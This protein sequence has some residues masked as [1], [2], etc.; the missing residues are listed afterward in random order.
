MCGDAAFYAAGA[1][2]VGLPVTPRRLL[3]CQDFPTHG[4]PST[5]LCDARQRIR[6]VVHS[7]G[8]RSV[9]PIRNSRPWRLSFRQKQISLITMSALATTAVVPLV[10]DSHGGIRVLLADEDFNFDI[11]RGLLRRRPQFDIVPVHDVDLSRTP[12]WETLALAATPN[13][14]PRS[15]ASLTTC[16]TQNEKE[17]LAAALEQRSRESHINSRALPTR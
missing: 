14:P 12:D 10:T 5:A 8:C 9:Q 1:F 13:S 4:A 7:M 6:Q 16:P 2:G 17:H 11:V 15:T 3:C